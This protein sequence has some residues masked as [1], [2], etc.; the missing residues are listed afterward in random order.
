MG[1]NKEQ[2]IV[3]ALKLKDPKERTQIV[4]EFVPPSE[5]LAALL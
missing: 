3:P 2:E 4:V 1:D 5:L